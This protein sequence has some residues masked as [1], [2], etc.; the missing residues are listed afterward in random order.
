[1]SAPLPIDAEG[2]FAG[3][4]SVFGQLD[5]GGDIVMPGAFRK[6]LGLRGRFG[7]GHAGENWREDG[8]RAGGRGRGR[9][10]CTQNIMRATQGQGLPCAWAGGAGG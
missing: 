5:D 7:R 8:A 3:Y 2:R 1:M 9:V 10:A 6:G 4:A